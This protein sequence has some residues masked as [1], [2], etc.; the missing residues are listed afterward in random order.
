VYGGIHDPGQATA[1]ANG[2]RRD[3]VDALREIRMPL[4]RYPGGNFVSSY[5]WEE[6]VG[7]RAERP[8]RLDLAWRS[9][10]PNLIGTNEFMDWLELVDSRPM[11]AVNLGT[12]EA[13]P[14]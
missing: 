12:R 1:D 2:F 3:V 7:P 11:A 13:M 10:E 4:V 5:I 6:G 9:L 14:L 8:V